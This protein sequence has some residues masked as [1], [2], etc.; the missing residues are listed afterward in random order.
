MLESHGLSDIGPLRKKNE[1]AWLMLPEYRIFA[2]ADGIG[3]HNAGEVASSLAMDL[4]KHY[5]K[6]NT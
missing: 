3:G 1:D 4:L 5:V 2:I 6:K